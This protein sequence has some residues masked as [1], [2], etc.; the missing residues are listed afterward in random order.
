MKN[1]NKIDSESLDAINGGGF[2][3]KIDGAAY[4]IMPSTTTKGSLTISFNGQTKEV[5]MDDFSAAV[6][7]SSDGNKIAASQII[8]TSKSSSGVQRNDD[9]IIAGTLSK[10]F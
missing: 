5:T 1:E 8:G 2:I 9:P 4:S 7:S 10:L 6:Q 3:G